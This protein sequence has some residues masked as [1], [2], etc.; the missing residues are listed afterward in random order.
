MNAFCGCYE[1]ESLSRDERVA[2]MRLAA[3]AHADAATVRLAADGRRG[4]GDARGGR[5]DAPHGED[6]LAIARRH[7]GCPNREPEWL[8]LLA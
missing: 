2:L 6:A 7:A 5:Q 4:P 1:R 8:R 3:A